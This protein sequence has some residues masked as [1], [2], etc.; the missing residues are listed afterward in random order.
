M[1]L[2]PLIKPFPS[3]VNGSMAGNLTGIPSIINQL[4][5]MSYGFSWSGTSPVGTVS[6]QVSNDYA[7]AVDGTV[8]NPGTW[9]VLT[10]N[11]GGAAVTTIPVT[12]NTGNGLV[13]ILQTGAYAIRPIYTFTSGT[14]TL[15]AIFTAKVS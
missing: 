10:L 9:N 15:Q 8:A 6:I 1:S 13:D 4:S 2:R 5:M 14:G 12:G 7:L 3:I 11:F